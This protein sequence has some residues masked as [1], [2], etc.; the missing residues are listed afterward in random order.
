M[1]KPVVL[2]LAFLTR[3]THFYGLYE[4]LNND[5]RYWIIDLLLNVI[6]KNYNTN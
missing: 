5:K 3:A 2:H 1:K 4:I 6:T